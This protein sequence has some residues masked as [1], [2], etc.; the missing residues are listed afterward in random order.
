M[1]GY[2]GFSKSNNAVA[3]E[4]AGKMTA[5]RL[6][7]VLGCSTAAIK[8]VL[9]RSEWHHTSSWYNCT[10]Y[11]DEPILISIAREEDVSNLDPEAVAE[12]QENL[13]AIRRFDWD[14]K[15][16]QQQF[17]GCSVEW[18]EWSGS[19]NRPVCTNR[20]ANGC[21]VKIKGQT[22]TITLPTGEVV[23]KRLATRGLHIETPAPCPGQGQCSNPDPQHCHTENIV[24]N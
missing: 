8:E 2:D 24:N 9:S 14:R 4:A 18:L 15:G 11:Y 6:A 12:A 22:A 13:A 17:N 16:D 23:T 10:D 21:V 7:K 3:A 1:A 20:S 19:R 5:S